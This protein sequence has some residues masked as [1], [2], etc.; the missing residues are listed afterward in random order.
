MI[1]QPFFFHLTSVVFHIATAVLIF[2]LFKRFFKE[3]IAF[4]LSLIFLVHPANVEAVCF[5]S[6][7]QEVLFTF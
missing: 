2:Y 7:L 6:A 1:S 5:A 3:N 4:F